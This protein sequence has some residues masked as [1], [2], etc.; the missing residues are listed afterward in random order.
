MTNPMTSKDIEDLA[1]TARIELTPAEKEAFPKQISDIMDTA[2]LLRQVDTEE[3]PP[4]IYPVIQPGHMRDDVVMASLSQVD[5]LANG[6]DV[7]DGYF[8]VP[9]IIE[10][11]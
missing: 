6:P 4:T 9:R 10:E 1:A 3:V 8:R 11:D 5:A 7:V 2:K